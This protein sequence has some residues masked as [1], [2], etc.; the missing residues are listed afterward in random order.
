MRF[1]V[2]KRQEKWVVIDTDTGRYHGSFETKADAEA[3]AAQ[4]EASP[5]AGPGAKQGWELVFS[6]IYTEMQGILETGFEPFAVG[7]SGKVYFKR[8]VKK[9]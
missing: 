8:A 5:P 7:D 2:K 6:S 4:L 3:R 1:K 9:P